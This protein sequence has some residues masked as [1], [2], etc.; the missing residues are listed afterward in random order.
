MTMQTDTDELKLLVDDL[1]P[2]SNSNED[3]AG[4]GREG[5]RQMVGPSI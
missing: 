1:P 5:D 3:I 4:G 2:F